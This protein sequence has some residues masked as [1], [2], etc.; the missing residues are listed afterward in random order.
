MRRRIFYEVI[1]LQR[2]PA[3]AIGHEMANDVNETGARQS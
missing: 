2:L 3:K 1:L